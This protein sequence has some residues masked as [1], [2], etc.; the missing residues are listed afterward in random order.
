MLIYN[1][2]I[3]E[4]ADS[5]KITRYSK[6]IVSKEK[7]DSEKK[8][9]KKVFSPEVNRKHSM[10]VSL[11]RTKSAIYDLAK[12]N[13]WDWF[14]TLTFDPQ[15][16]DSTNYDTVVA[17]IKKFIDR[18][19]KTLAPDLVYLLVP[20]FHADKEKFH[21][22]GLF[23][24]VGYMQFVE[25]G[26]SDHSGNMIYN[27]YDWKYGFSTATKIQDSKKVSGYITK[28]ITKECM[29]H[30][31]NKRRYLSSKNIKRPQVSKINSPV[32]LM[33]IIETYQPDY[34][35]SVSVPQAHNKMTYLEIDDK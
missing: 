26:L 34:I 15:L 28:Y 1:T 25:S 32:D 19:R 29:I 33:D 13:Y 17:C 3:T 18:N 24:D 27:I 6:P 12:S 10:N 8:E 21:F 4:Y 5:T 9:A 16:V 30:T 35:S 2:K 22:H 20:E 23:A 31:K 14:V 11:N 7:S